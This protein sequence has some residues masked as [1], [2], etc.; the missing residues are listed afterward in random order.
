MEEVYFLDEDS[1]DR[2]MND[3]DDRKRT[4]GTQRAYR[5]TLTIFSKFLDGEPLNKESD[6]RWRDELVMLG[7]SPRTVN[8]RLSSLN[9]YLNYIGKPEWRAPFVNV[10]RNRHPAGL[11][12]SEY[13]CLL[14]TAQ[15]YAVEDG[16]YLIKMLCATGIPL[17]DI[18]CFTVEML[19]LNDFSK[20]RVPV[21]LL[22]ELREYAVRKGIRSGF[23]FCQPDGTLVDVSYIN[24][25]ISEV[26]EKTSIP[27]ERVTPHQLR[28]LYHN[29]YR[30]I[31]LDAVNGADLSYDKLLE[32]EDTAVGQYVI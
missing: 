10:D 21:N 24:D 31:T 12:R 25:R 8:A 9:S 23:L 4:E 15:R 27:K 16:Y 11:T 5:F 22:N 2:F 30:I 17:C 1:I 19:Y 3:L 26:C 32:I 6:K 29:T 7:Y 18:P 13:L 20:H 14:S 28:Q